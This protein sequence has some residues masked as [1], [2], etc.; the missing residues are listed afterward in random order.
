MTYRLA[1][2]SPI[3]VAADGGGY[4]ADVLWVRDLSEQVRHV[5]ALTL[6]CP[7]AAPG[8]RLAAATAHLPEGIRVLDRKA[9]ER[10]W[11]RAIGDAEVLQIPG[12]SGW[13]GAAPLRRAASA[14]RAHGCKVVIGISSNRARTYRLNAKGP[15]VVRQLRGL[16]GSWSIR[17]AERD[18]TRRADGAFVVGSGLLPQVHPRCPNVHV[19][20]ASW[21]SARELTADQPRWRGTATGDSSVRLCAAARL[22]AMKGVDLAVAALAQLTTTEAKVDWQL[23]I[24]G[25]GAEQA[26]LAAQ[27]AALG[28]GAR[29]RLLGTRAYPEAFF[30]FLSTQ[31]FVLLT[32]RNDEQ[33]R[34][35]FDAIARG[36]LPICPDARAYLDLGVPPELLYRQGS[37]AALAEQIASL[38][39]RSPAALDATWQRLLQ[40]AQKHGIESMHAT[41]AAWIDGAVLGR[42]DR[43]TGS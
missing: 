33:P 39:A 5:R 12:G 17:S 4:V 35:L 28:L 32:N 13:S 29:A 24:L 7:I 41:R 23:E 9:A 36:C 21:I 27:I 19:G 1:I 43:H 10:D 30:A 2:V 15:P 38:R 42:R 11:Q 31:H 34:L 14:A 16:L 22:E 40:L 26:A 8:Q 20:I 18:L 3:A 37:A 6:I 25:E